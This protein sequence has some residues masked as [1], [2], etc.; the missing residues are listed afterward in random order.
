MVIGIKVTTNFERRAVRNAVKKANFTSLGKAG[1]FVRQV[2]RRSI[3]KRGVGGKPS[4]PGQPPKSTGPL[5]EAILFELSPQKDDVSIGPSFGGFGKLGRVH[6]DGLRVPGKQFF[7]T[8]DG[9][10]KSRRVVRDYP[11]RPFAE[12]ALKK[13]QPRLQKFWAN[14]VK[15]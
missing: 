5:R 12:P 6:E 9:R 8:P 2:M 14:S 1:A 4:A 13:S 15:S 7:K 11:E 10:S 3:R